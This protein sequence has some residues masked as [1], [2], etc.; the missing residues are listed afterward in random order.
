[1]ANSY[2]KQVIEDGQRNFIVKITGILDTSD[3]PRETLVLPSDCVQFIPTNFRVDHIDY[4]ISDP[5]EVQL[6]WEGTPDSLILPMAGRNKFN[7]ADLGGLQNTANQPTGGIRFETTGYV[8]GT[9][10][11]SLMLWLVK[12]GVPNV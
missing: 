2:T 1:M 9:Q 7:Y 5:I 4:T 12:Q 6:W 3:Q 10:V 11:Y 8:S